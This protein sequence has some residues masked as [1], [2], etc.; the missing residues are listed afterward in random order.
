VAAAARLVRAEHAD[1]EPGAGEGLPPDQRRRQP[2]RDAQLAH[3]V[4]VVVREW[5][6]DSPLVAQLPH[7]LGVVVVRLNHLPY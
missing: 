2:E 5:L 4:L 3:L 1:R 7:E 6:E